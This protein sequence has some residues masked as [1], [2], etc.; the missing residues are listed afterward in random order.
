MHYHHALTA[1]TFDCKL[2]ERARMIDRKSRDRQS[3]DQWIRLLQVIDKGLKRH[4]VALE[5]KYA[6]G[7]V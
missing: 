3:V 1:I 5:E 7:E 4:T 2:C 6:L